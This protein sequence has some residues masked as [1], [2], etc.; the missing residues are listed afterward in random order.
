MSTLT[1]TPVITPTN[2]PTQTGTQPPAFVD[3]PSNYAETLGGTSYP[4]YAYIQALWDAGYTAGCS[5]NPL[6]YCPA[7]T[8]TRAESAVFMLRGNFGS[9]YTPPA[10][11]WNTFV[12]DW[13]PGLWAEK[14]AQG[15]WNAGMT[16]GC[17][18][19]PLRFCP[20]D[21]FP[22]DQAAVFGLRMKYGMNY[23]PPPATGTVFADMTDTSYWG[24]KWAEQAYL[25]GLLPVCGTQGGKPLFCPN[26][27]VDRAWGAYLIVKAK[28]L[29]LAP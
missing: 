2:T 7:Q 25:D 4:L 11:P 23:T 20:W 16:A 13:T 17:L 28:D 9:G 1:D 21:Q 29:P 8:M 22:R 6:S 18:T 27:L 19:N 12:D 10:G 26:D 3:V 14:W 5:T 15:M 24:T